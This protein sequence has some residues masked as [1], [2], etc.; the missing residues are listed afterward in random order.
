MGL[1]ER[2]W[3]QDLRKISISAVSEEIITIIRDVTR[4]CPSARVLLFGS[5]A[6]KTSTNGSD[7]DMAIILPD[8]FDKKTFK[9]CFYKTRTRIHI[10]VD[11]IFRNETEFRESKSE[12]PVDSEIH[13]KGIELYPHWNY[14]D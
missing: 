10:P 13:Q 1:A 5:F 7:L 3:G 4:L 2:L 6:A 8:S 9:K 11:F 12:N 14:H